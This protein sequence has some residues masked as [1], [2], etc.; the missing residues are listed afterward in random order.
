M[1]FRVD[2][3]DGTGSRMAHRR[4]TDAVFQVVCDSERN[5]VL[6]ITTNNLYFCVYCLFSSV[7]VRLSVLLS[8]PLFLVSFS[9]VERRFRFYIS[10][11]IRFP[12]G[13]SLNL[14]SRYSVSLSDS[15]FFF[16]LFSFCFFFSFGLL[17]L[18]FDRVVSVVAIIYS[19]ARSLLAT[20]FYL[21]Y[22]KF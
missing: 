6:F 21:M 13:S 18:L 7:S 20:L 5:Q 19:L 12:C 22:L 17:F 16:F 4:T 8:F 3:W 2:R 11:D 10:C 15:T 1:G 9:D 14:L